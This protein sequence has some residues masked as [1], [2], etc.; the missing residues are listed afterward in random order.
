MVQNLAARRRYCAPHLVDA[1]PPAEQQLPED[2]QASA[3]GHLNQRLGRR[4]CL[5]SYACVPKQV[6]L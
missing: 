3:G 6:S 4:L 1:A 2:S 5:S